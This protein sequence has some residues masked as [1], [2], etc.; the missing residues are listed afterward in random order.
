M[1]FIS[2]FS[3]FFMGKAFAFEVGET[4]QDCPE[5]PEMVVL[6]KGTFV[7]GDKNSRDKREKPAHIVFFSK[8]FAMGKFELT[9]ENWEACFNDKGCAKIPDDHG[10]G[11]VGRPVINVDIVEVEQYL[12]W[13]SKKTGATYRLPSEAEWEYA[14]RGGT[15]TQYWFGDKVGMGK[16]NCRKC[17]TPWS[18]KGSAPVGT[19]PANPYGLHEMNGNIWEW[20]GDCWNPNHDGAKSN[21]ETR[22]TGDCNY[23]V[24]RGGSWYYFSKL[25]RGAYR[26][27]ND[28]RVFS[29]NIGFRVLRE[30]P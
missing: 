15:T 2:L 1:V 20:A 4:F 19:F 6:P 26:Y 25:S 13:L 29:Y 11:K 10:W 17:G 12:A 8:P 18:G 14:A 28:A 3:L 16:V 21:G 7:M 23:R 30:L 24:I 22:L 9:F 5:C 27:R